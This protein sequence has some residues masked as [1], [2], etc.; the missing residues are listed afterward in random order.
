MKGAS[1]LS[2]ARLPYLLV[3]V[4]HG[5][6]TWHTARWI[7]HPLHYRA[8]TYGS[9][10]AL[11]NYLC[12]RAAQVQQTTASSLFVYARRCRARLYSAYA[13]YSVL[14]AQ[15]KERSVGARCAERCGTLGGAGGGVID[16]SREG[17]SNAIECRITNVKPVSEGV[18]G[19][20]VRGA[21]LYT[22]Y[23]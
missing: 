15:R 1:A 23:S 19:R 17:R 2:W 18:S 3:G 22:N 9:V 5:R 11:L 21:Y 13:V 20:R 14:Y 8:C 12:L 16:C 10:Q 6:Q 4:V 7:A